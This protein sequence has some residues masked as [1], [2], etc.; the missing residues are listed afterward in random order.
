MDESSGDD[1]DVV[2]EIRCVADFFNV[3]EEKRQHC[4]HDFGLWVCG[5][6][7]KERWLNSLPMVGYIVNRTVYTWIDDGEHDAYVKV[8]VV[9][10]REKQA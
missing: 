10:D 8:T 6:E 5:L 7:S 4:L 1:G 9:A 2:Y 3:P